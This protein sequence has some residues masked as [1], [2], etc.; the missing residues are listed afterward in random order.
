VY[1]KPKVKEYV[2]LMD[3]MMDTMA[4][5]VEDNKQVVTK[6]FN[7][8]WTKG[9]PAV[10]DELGADDLVFYYPLTGE[11]K[12]REAVKVCNEALFGAFDGLTFWT[13][14]PLIAEGDKVVGRWKGKGVHTGEFAGIAATGKQI[15]F[16]GTTIYR[17]ADGKIVEE[18]GEEDAWLVLRQLGVISG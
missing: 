9:N 10:V 8:Y 3:T 2:M 1:W 6:W 15:A 13:T 16:T 12:G 5:T 7:E 4:D 14:E 17:V 18:T 11:L